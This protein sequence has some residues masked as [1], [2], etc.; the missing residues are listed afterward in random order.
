M[1]H[2]D[3]VCLKFHGVA[4]NTDP[5]PGRRVTCD[6]NVGSP[7][8]NS[9]SESN[10][11]RHVKNYDPRS[12]SFTRGPKTTWATIVEIGHHDD[13]T[14][15]AT[16]RV[17]ASTPSARKRW[18]FSLRQIPRRCG[19]GKIRFTF[20]RPCLDRRQCLFKHVVRKSIRSSQALICLGLNRRGNARV[21]LP[22][23]PAADE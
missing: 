5:V 15:A 3:V 9:I 7:H 19:A 23:T 18:Y 12:S 20:S 10:D 22:P 1:A 21:T 14:P 4:R 2:D 6:G 16:K 13:A 17:H 11:S 8:A